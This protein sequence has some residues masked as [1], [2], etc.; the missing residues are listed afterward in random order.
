MPKTAIVRSAYLA[1]LDVTPITLD[2]AVTS[3]LSNV[4]IL[5]V[6]DAAALETISRVRCAIRAA[7]FEM[8]QAGI[9]VQAHPATARPRGTQL[10]LAIAAAILAATSQVPPVPDDAVLVGE[11]ALDGRVMSTRGL[12]CYGHWCAGHGMAL[13]CP[14]SHGNTSYVPVDTLGNLRTLDWEPVH[15]PGVS[16]A[17]RTPVEPPEPLRAAW[18]AA[19]DRHALLLVRGAD[20]P[21]S[22]AVRSLH[23]SLPQLTQDQCT[24][25]SCIHS[26]CRDTFEGDPPFR[27]PHHSITMAGMVGGG[28]P[29]MPGEVT[30]ATHGL[31]LVSDI[32]CFSDGVL[33]TLRVAL[34]DREARIVRAEGVWSM[35]A[36]PAL[37]VA[38]TRDT[39]TP[40]RQILRALAAL[41]VVEVSL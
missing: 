37:V 41:E 25:L 34:Q 9:V 13:V 6:G 26:A 38:T 15:S 11:L 39:K 12:A 28:R 4:R 21:V 5:G 20:G 10:D 14:T 40:S 24:E 17:P 7:D 1:G 16:P 8:P 27:A 33:S 2:C 30:L 32:E 3:G 19:M 23:A 22:R 29:V 36:A 35:P 31:L 18:E